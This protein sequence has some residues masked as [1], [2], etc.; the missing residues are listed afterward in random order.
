[1]AGLRGTPEVAV[2]IG[3]LLMAPVFGVMS[4]AAFRAIGKEDKPL[5]KVALGVGG[6]VFG[7]NALSAL[8]VGAVAPFSR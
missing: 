7:I 5:F 2:G 3:L 8:V 6:V 4:Y 1:M